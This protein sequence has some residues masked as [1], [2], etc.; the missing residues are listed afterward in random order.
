MEND[1]IAA[2]GRDFEYIDEI[3]FGRG[4]EKGRGGHSDGKGPALSLFDMY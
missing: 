3:D 2:P 1:V 4:T